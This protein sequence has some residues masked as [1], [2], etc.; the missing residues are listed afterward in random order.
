VKTA[1][2]N[3]RGIDDQKHERPQRGRK[4]AYE[5]R[6]AE[7]RQKLTVWKDIPESERPSL[8]ALARETNTSHQLLAFFLKG[9]EEWQHQDRYRTAK[10]RALQNAEEI[11]SRA[12]AENREMTLRECLDSIVSPGWIEQVESLRHAAKRGPLNWY[13]GQMLKIYAR[14]GILGA[15]ELL[16]QCLQ[17]GLLKRKSF[18]GIVK[19]T[20]RQDR[21]APGGWVRRIWDE[22]QRYG[23]SS[24]AVLTEKL[25]LRYSGRKNDDAAREFATSAG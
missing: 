1:E 22:C 8:R 9:L 23:T 11:R 3:T 12:A 5:S 16:R 18:A 6:A 15:P 20:P 4:P 25:L 10:R 19:D 21:E 13:Q 17:V 14:R 24:R 7:L 2:A